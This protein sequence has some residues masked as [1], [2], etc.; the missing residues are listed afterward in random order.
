MRIQSDIQSDQSKDDLLR[1][2]FAPNE[3][4]SPNPSGNSER[5]VNRSELT[6]P[7]PTHTNISSQSQGLS[8][9][10]KPT[11]RDSKKKK[12]LEQLKQNR[13]ITN[14]TTRKKIYKRYS[15]LKQLSLCNSKNKLVLL[16]KKLPEQWKAFLRFYMTECF[17]KHLFIR[18]IKNCSGLFGKRRLFYEAID[19]PT[20]IQNNAHFGNNLIK[21]FCK[22]ICNFVAMFYGDL[23]K[24]GLIPK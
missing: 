22:G 12:F 10:N 3:P 8:H 19:D 17:I 14:R 5:L 20:V 1:E 18:Q 4:C 15:F 6:H 16:F 24:N 9:F 7:F 11:G 23:R 2:I 21:N 13:K